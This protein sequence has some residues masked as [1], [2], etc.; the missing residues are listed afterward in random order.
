MLSGKTQKHT[1]VICGRGNM[2]KYKV[3]YDAIHRASQLETNARRPKTIWSACQQADIFAVREILLK[4]KE[5]TANQKNAHGNTP[6][7][8]AVQAARKYEGDL[9]K[10]A[11]CVRIAIILLQPPGRRETADIHAV[12]LIGESPLYLAC[13]YSP[14]MASLFKKYVKW[15]GAMTK[16][17]E[18]FLLKSREIGIERLHEQQI[19]KREWALQMNR[20]R[21]EAKR[22]LVKRQRQDENMKLHK[23]G[24]SKTRSSKAK[25]VSRPEKHW[26]NGWNKKDIFLSN[27]H[28][29]FTTNQKLLEYNRHIR[30]RDRLDLM[31]LKTVEAYD[32]R[33]AESI[34]S[35]LYRIERQKKY[36]K[37]MASYYRR[38]PHSSY[39]RDRGSRGALMHIHRVEENRRIIH[40]MPIAK[41]IKQPKD[42]KQPLD[43]RK[44]V[45]AGFFRLDKEQDIKEAFNTLAG[46]KRFINKN[47]LIKILSTR[48]DT[49][50]LSEAFDM[51]ERVEGFTLAE[52]T[53]NIDYETFVETMMWI[54]KQEDLKDS[55]TISKINKSE[56]FTEW[57]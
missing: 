26:R 19:L 18:L 40:S 25:R 10:L 3:V 27:I 15:K 13:K 8:Y 41:P 57:Y 53:N 6:L 48:G 42:C 9:E 16:E 30:V 23:N 11:M 20:Q 38:R 21:E 31:R 4:R 28:S 7:Y 14:I 32:K 46:G 50:K 39:I 1:Y 44:K 29:K 12:N 5:A 49:L 52:N 36:H 34:R 55:A 56:V 24:V 33:K 43:L 2:S 35:R 45:P 22:A 47:K 37:E 51:L 17:E 54:S